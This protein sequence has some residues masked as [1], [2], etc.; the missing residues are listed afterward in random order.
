M[1]Q[2]FYGGESRIKNDNG[3]HVYVIYRDSAIYNF[4]GYHLIPSKDRGGSWEKESEF[5]D[6]TATTN[7]ADPTS[8]D[9]A[10][11]SQYIYTVV[12]Y[13]VGQ[14]SRLR[15]RRNTNY[16]DKNSWDAGQWIFSATPEMSRKVKISAYGSTVFMAWQDWRQSNPDVYYTYSLDRGANW[17]TPVQL[18]N[19]TSNTY[20]SGEIQLASSSN[21][22]Y[23]VWTNYNPVSQKF[24]THFNYMQ[25]EGSPTPSPILGTP[26]QLNDGS[27][28]ARHPAIVADWQNVYIAWQDNRYG[29]FDILGRHS[30]DGGRNWSETYRWNTNEQGRSHAIKPQL[31]I[32]TSWMHCVWTDYRYGLNVF[33]E[34]RRR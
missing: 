5:T 22:L 9:F 18:D 14:D 3:G 1:P 6:E 30:Q 33:Y 26:F 8:Y 32:A 13:Q 11:E 27:G 2:E 15:F 34:Q 16:G 10:L 23:A 31:Q 12:T 19:D 29:T 20:S 4:N 25:L 24:S 7:F 21:Q 28:N 17:Q